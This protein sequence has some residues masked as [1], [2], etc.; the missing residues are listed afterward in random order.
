MRLLFLPKYSADGPSSRH[1]FFAVADRLRDEGHE[2]EVRPLFHQGYVTRFF[3]TGSRLSAGIVRDYWRRLARL[4]RGLGGA[5]MAVI[6][7]EALPYCPLALEVRLL[8]PL[9]PWA[10]DVDDAVEVRYRGLPRLHSKI[11]RLFAAADGIVAGNSVLASE[12]SRLNPRVTCVPTGVHSTRYQPKGAGEYPVRGRPVVIGWMGSPTSFKYLDIVSAPIAELATRHSLVLRVVGP[13][14][15]PGFGGVRVECVPWVEAEESSRL[16]SFDIGVMPLTDD[17]FARGKSGF[18][19][20]QYMAAG[21]PCVASDVGCNAEI[22][23]HGA[24]GLL[25]SSP[26]EWVV[27]LERLLVDQTARASLGAAAHRR[28]L[29][30]YTLERLSRRR[31][32][33]YSALLDRGRTAEARG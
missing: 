14:Q 1:R 23:D 18:K 5:D 26:Q 32:E 27:G 4:R 33:F 28:F 29:E 11:G 16:R 7:Y 15:L 10:L 24:A 8:R 13:R 3:R 12:L 30:Q 6:E 19:L 21:L 2:V 31:M 9:R 22:L 20:I 17:A 25:V